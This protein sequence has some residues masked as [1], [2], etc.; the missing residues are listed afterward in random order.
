MVAF[1]PVEYWNNRLKS[2][3]TV[4]TS[5]TA[6]SRAESN[7][8]I[9][10]IKQNNYVLDYGVGDG[11]LFDIYEA[12][13]CDVIGFDIADYTELIN[14]KIANYSFIYFNL[15]KNKIEPLIEFKDNSFDVV[16]CFNTLNHIPVEHIEMVI[17]DIKRLGKI[18]LLT[19]YDNS[20][21]REMKTAEHC[22][23]HDFK[24]IFKKLNI[25]PLSY[26]KNK[27]NI[28]FIVI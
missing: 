13:Q 6:L 4:N 10:Y 8:C 18:A 25:T 5:K 22:F 16:C 20:D 7:F 26:F 3:G 28:C 9:K 12:K 21:N 19:V 15:I 11:K 24:A 23:N 1:N 27:Y 14:S 17:K 2:Y